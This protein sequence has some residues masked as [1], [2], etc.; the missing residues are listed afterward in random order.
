MIALVGAAVAVFLTGFGVN[1]VNGVMR[2]T[3]RV[4]GREKGA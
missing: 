2:V 1:G 4:K 3:V